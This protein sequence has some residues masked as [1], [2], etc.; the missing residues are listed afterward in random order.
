[1]ASKE[2]IREKVN[3]YTKLLDIAVKR[4]KDTVDLE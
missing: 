1:M 2:I 4:Y 3:Y